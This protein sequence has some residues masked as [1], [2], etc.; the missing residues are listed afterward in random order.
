MLIILPRPP[1]ALTASRS[2]ELSVSRCVLV[3][4]RATGA[5]PRSLDPNHGDYHQQE[6]DGEPGK[7]QQHGE[8]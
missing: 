8:Q 7:D 4:V 2:S 1:F 3:S 6:D 5:L